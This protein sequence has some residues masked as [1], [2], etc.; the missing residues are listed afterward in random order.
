MRKIPDSIYKQV[1]HT[2]ATVIVVHSHAI[3]WWR[4][5]HEE[6]DQIIT[7]EIHCLK[8]WDL[9]S[10]EHLEYGHRTSKY[11]IYTIGGFC[12]DCGE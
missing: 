10:K 3:G 12:N 7:Q 4:T 2:I 9:N 11:W 8:T 5:E 6:I 1:S